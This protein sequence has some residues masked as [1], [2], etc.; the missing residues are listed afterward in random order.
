MFDKHFYGRFFKSYDFDTEKA[1]KHWVIYCQWRK[2]QNIDT[3]LVS[4]TEIFLTITLGF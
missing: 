4:E 1:L 2:Q 3:I